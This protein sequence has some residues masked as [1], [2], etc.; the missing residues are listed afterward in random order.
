LQP[1][2][3]AQMAVAKLD[4]SIAESRKAE[5]AASADEARDRDN[6]TALKGN[7]AA[8]R[9]VDELN[10]AED[11][12]QAAR[13]KTADLEQQKQTAVAKLNTLIGSLNFDWDVKAE[14]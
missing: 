9:F 13:K 14:K 3:D 10:R 4:W 6:L 12:L 5:A 8:K 7:E 2:I 11:T 1:V